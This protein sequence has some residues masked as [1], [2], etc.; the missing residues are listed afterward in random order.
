MNTLTYS[1]SLQFKILMRNSHH[2]LLCMIKFKLEVTKIIKSI[3]PLK[4]FIKFIVT[5]FCT[6]QLLTY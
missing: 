6:Y 5:H 1:N 3:I 2:L 4:N